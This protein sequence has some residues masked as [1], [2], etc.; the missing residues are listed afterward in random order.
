MRRVAHSAVGRRLADQPLRNL[1][2]VGTGAILLVTAAFGGLEPAET[3]GPTTFAFGDTVRAAPLDITVDRVTWLDGE[4][5]GVYLTDDENRWIGVVATVT[6]DHSASL[7][8]EPSYTVGLAGVE[9]LL[10]DPVDG[11]DAVLSADQLLMADASRLSP[12]QPGLTYEVVYLFEQDGDVLPPQEVELVLLGHTWRADTFDGTFGWKDPAPVARATLA[13]RP[14]AGQATDG[15]ADA[16]AADVSD[17][18]TEDD[19]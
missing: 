11:V 13:A 12:M 15:D 1:G 9:G 7:S 8:A 5:P 2:A 17:A 4:L 19:A 16:S 14:A 6:T 10:G 3:A 18:G